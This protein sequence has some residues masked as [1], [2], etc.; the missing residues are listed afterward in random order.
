MGQPPLSNTEQKKVAEAAADMF[1]AHY[2]RATP[3]RA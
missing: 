3:Q 2:E 1:L